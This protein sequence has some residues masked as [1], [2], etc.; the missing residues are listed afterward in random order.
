MWC[1]KNGGRMEGS[2]CLSSTRFERSAFSCV[3]VLMA[4]SLRRRQSFHACAR[5]LMH[6]LINLYSPSCRA[7][8]GSRPRAR[9][10]SSFGTRGPTPPDIISQGWWRHKLTQRSTVKWVSRRSMGDVSVL[11][12]SDEEKSSYMP[13]RSSI[14]PQCFD[15]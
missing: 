15:D 13:N 1:Q 12:T 5:S 14:V 10:K 8:L 7:S 2:F 6:T 9:M 11:Q 4:S 3:Y